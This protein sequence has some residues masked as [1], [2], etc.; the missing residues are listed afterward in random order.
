MDEKVLQSVIDM[1]LSLLFHSALKNTAR[2]E[3]KH[4]MM[5]S[6]NYNRYLLKGTSILMEKSTWSLRQKLLIKSL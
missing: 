1:A 2:L 3:K 6:Y 4:L 5:S